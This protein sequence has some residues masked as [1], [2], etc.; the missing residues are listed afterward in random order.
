MRP[1]LA[2]VLVL[3][4]MVGTAVTGSAAAI[5]NTPAR[6]GSTTAAVAL[7]D[8][9]FNYSNQRANDPVLGGA[10]AVTNVTVKLISQPAC[11]GRTLRVV[12]LDAA[13]QVLG[14]QQSA[15]LTAV[16]TSKTL[17]FSAQH[18]PDAN[19]VSIL[20]VAVMP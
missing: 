16:D 3:A 14:V 10:K 18:I 19:L 8:N 4:L 20:A 1:Y 15:V 6:L 9:A 5:T 2:L 7:C 11:S 17:D 12:L 13:N